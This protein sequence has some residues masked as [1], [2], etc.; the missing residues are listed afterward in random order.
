MYIIGINLYQNQIR[1]IESHPNTHVIEINGNDYNTDWCKWHK[2]H[3]FKKCLPAIGPALW[4]D[5]DTIITREIDDLF[6][7]ANRKFFVISD[8]F[9]PSKCHNKHE[10]YEL[11][12]TKRR[13]DARVLNS[14]VIGGYFPRDLPIIE[15][16][17]SN[18]NRAMID[19]EFKDNITL[20]DQ[21]TLLLTLHQLDSLDSILNKVDWN[22]PGK[23]INY[24][25]RSDIIEQAK[26]DHPN[27]TIIH[28]AGVPK[29]NDLQTHN[30]PK[31]IQYYNKKLGEYKPNNII[32]LGD[33]PLCAKIIKLLRQHTKIGGLYQYIINVSE[34]DVT[35]FDNLQYPL[36]CISGPDIQRVAANSKSKKI[37]I[38]GDKYTSIR[39]NLVNYRI[40]PKYV[41]E[42]PGFY[43]KEYNK[44]STAQM[45]MNERL[46]DEG[47]LIESLITNYQTTIDESQMIADVKMTGAESE[48]YKQL[49]ALIDDRIVAIP[50]NIQHH[51]KT[52]TDWANMVLHGLQ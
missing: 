47:T 31:T 30:H 18:V 28:Y 8:Y 20:H 32:L 37:A 9:A 44:L 34:E 48:I 10:L 36:S 14:G 51:D 49:N 13:N 21:G 29:L 2:P 1:F 4:I 17:E 16:W 46:S 7:E 40:H 43:Q 33:E 39:D 38:I 27:A 35:T 41:I 50:D 45:M 25:H 5:V 23:R 52:A 12:K 3:H 6:T 11:A 24:Q 26:Q 42:C 22:H 19:E 15:L